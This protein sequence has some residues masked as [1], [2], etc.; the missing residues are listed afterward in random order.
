MPAL[1][2]GKLLAANRMAINPLGARSRATKGTG[3]L[4]ED[5]RPNNAGKNFE[6]RADCERMSQSRS[7]EWICLRCCNIKRAMTLL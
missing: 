4:L 2:C 6:R 3:A 5:T 7:K 1:W